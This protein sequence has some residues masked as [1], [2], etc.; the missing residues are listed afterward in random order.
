MF[1]SVILEIA[2]GVIF[3]Y[4]LLSLI[5]SALNEWIAR[6][7]SLRSTTLEKGI[8]SLL[9]EAKG[10]EFTK[11]LY[12]HSLIK[13]FTQPGWLDKLF[14]R[15]P[16]PSYIPSRTFTLALLDTLGIAYSKKG[17]KGIDKIQN[18]ELRNSLQILLKEAGHD[19]EKAIKN[20]ES[21]FNDTMDRISGWYKR[22]V[23][24]IILVLALLVSVMLNAD[25]F[26]IANGISSNDTMRTA[27]VAFAQEVSKQPLSADAKTSLKR[28]EE[29][30]KNFQ[31]IQLPIGWSKRPKKLPKD[32]LY[33]RD[34]R[35]VPQGFTGWLLKVIGLLFT[36]IAISLGGPFWF[37]V[38]S[39]FINLRQTGGRPEPISKEEIKK[40]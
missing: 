12:E 29:I 5:C 3:I 13:V 7:L 39:K 34:P 31:N 23:Q 17:L 2:I 36:T 40:G 33:V 19:L 30:Q 37:D 35:E 8:Q 24:L 38:L 27:I 25:T 1:G 15:E 18:N 14:K 26:M 6:L 10:G 21:W 4:L 28:I 9:N 32:E 11:K 16:K 20:I 22:K